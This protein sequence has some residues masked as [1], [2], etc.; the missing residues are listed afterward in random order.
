[1]PCCSKIVSSG[2]VAV[3]RGRGKK[4]PAQVF[5]T[6]SAIASF[7]ASNCYDRI[8]HAIASLSL[9]FQA[10]GVEQSIDAYYNSGDAVFSEDCVRRLNE[11]RK[12]VKYQGLCQGNGAAP[13]GWAAISVTILGLSIYRY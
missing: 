7:D 6:P 5:R 10:F 4:A 12:E 3:T 13:A 9:V 11:V 1:M 2:I 8:A